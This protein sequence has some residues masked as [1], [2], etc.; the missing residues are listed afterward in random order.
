MGWRDELSKVKLPDGRE[1]VAG[2]FRGVAF[3]TVDAEMR[4]GRRNVVNEYPQ[5]DDPYVDDLGR[6]A[7]RF[8]VEAYVIGQNY[9]AERDALIA[10][11]ETKGPGELVHP[12]YGLRKVSVDGDVSVK[13]SPERGGMARISVTFVEDSANIFPQAVENTVSKVESA[14][15]VADDAAQACF[16][17]DFSVDGPSVLATQALGGLKG[18]TAS[19][20]GLLAMARQVASVA[21]LAT[22][23]GQVGALTGTL[24]ALIRTPV[25]LVQ[26]LRSIHAQLVQE[27]ERPLAAFAELQAVFFGNTRVAAVS[28]V[29]STIARSLV[30]DNARADLQRR[31][32]LSNQARVL[33]VALAN[34]DVVATSEQATALRDAL[35]LQLDIELEVN[36]P[37]AEVAT[38]LTA[39]RAAVV[40]DVAVRAEFL[41][42]RSTYTPQAVLPAL[43]LAHRIY[44]D[45]ARFEE[46]VARNGVSHP[47]FMPASALEVLV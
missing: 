16:A 11:F 32:S 38:A 1:L 37:P 24:A 2:S 18:L 31:L 9:L 5:R 19:A 43:V 4:V 8:V 28:P 20:A 34:I 17:K 3:R 47:A 12:R 25:V 7:R 22:I 33:A 21:G 36:D 10:A 15:N 44:Q 45:A 13:E 30:N 39:L 41:L 40:R 35:V 6:K 46:L 26:S 27:V 14:A 23:V 29:G 42:K